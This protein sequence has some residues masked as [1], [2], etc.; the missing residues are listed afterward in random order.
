VTAARP[1]HP[2]VGI[3]VGGAS[4]R[5]GGRPKGLLRAPS[6]PTI[7]ESWQALAAE[8][9]LPAVLVGDGGAY[10]ALGI[11]NVPDA[12]PGA[13]PLGG[14]VGLLRRRDAAEVIAVACDMPHVTAPLLARLAFSPAEAAVLAP[15]RDGRFEPLF[16]RYESARVLPLAEAQLQTEDLSLQRLLRTAGAESLELGVDEWPLLADWDEPAD[17]DG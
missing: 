9:G 17:R 13:G 16:A 12:R 4:R 10:G 11:E 15:V 6:G 1:F 3:L 7:V 5:M 14:L 8:L 2:L